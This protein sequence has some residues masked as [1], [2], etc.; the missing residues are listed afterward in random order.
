VADVSGDSV[1]LNVGRSQG[2]EVGTILRLL[3]VSRRVKDPVTGKPLREIT[4][5]VGQVRIVEADANS[6][7]GMITTH[8]DTIKVGDLVRN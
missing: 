6:S 5:D 7:T 2:I 1:I 4:T 3:R 8:N